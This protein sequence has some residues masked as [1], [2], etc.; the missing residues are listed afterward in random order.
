MTHTCSKLP[1]DNDNKILPMEEIKDAIEVV[2]RMKYIDNPKAKKVADFIMDY[3][4]RDTEQVY[5][6]NTIIVPLYRV[7][8]ALIMIDQDEIEYREC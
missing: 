4:F 6:N 1:S 7:L 2:S 8:D 5:T 3:A